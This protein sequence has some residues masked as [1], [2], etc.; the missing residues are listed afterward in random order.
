MG[1]GVG[2]GETGRAGVRGVGSGLSHVVESDFGA[3][4][5]SRLCHLSAV[6]LWAY[7][8][9]L[10]IPGLVPYKIKMTSVLQEY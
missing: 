10:R 7:S 1:W 5:Q 3:G 8:L 6:Q 9:T 2:A 4:I